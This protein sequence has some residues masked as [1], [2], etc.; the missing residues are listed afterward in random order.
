M[1]GSFAVEKP[2]SAIG[3][4]KGL[5]VVVFGHSAAA[6]EVTPFRAVIITEDIPRRKPAGF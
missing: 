5:E 2:C 6:V 3:A 1:W 4:K